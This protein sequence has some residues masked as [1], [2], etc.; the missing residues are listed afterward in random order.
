M[1]GEE[2]L[3]ELAEVV[4]VVR[5]ESTPLLHVG[6][7]LLDLALGQ[8]PVRRLPRL[9]HGPVEVERRRLAFRRRAF[10]GRFRPQLTGRREMVA[11][12]RPADLRPHHVGDGLVEG[13]HVLGGVVGA[14]HRVEKKVMV[15]PLVGRQLQHTLE[16][17]AVGDQAGVGGD[18]SQP[19]HQ[20]R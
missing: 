19:L 10:G 6:L 12:H 15:S 16:R 11:V 14:A 20:R 9:A 7:G 1:K 4:A 2:G 5:Q 3:V 17:R 18:A 8:Q 13:G